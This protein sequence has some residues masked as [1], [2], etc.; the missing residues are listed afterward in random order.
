MFFSF[1]KYT[2][3]DRFTVIYSNIIIV[4]MFFFKFH[5]KPL[6]LQ[7][8]KVYLLSFPPF[9]WAEFFLLSLPQK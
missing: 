8:G 1:H 7:A 6:V 5:T 3:K 2:L 9:R 4:S